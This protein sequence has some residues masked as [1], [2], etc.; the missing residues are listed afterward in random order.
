[1]AK[2]RV[3]GGCVLISGQR[4]TH[5][6][7]AGM[8]GERVEMGLHPSGPFAVI[9][10]EEAP[11]TL[12]EEGEEVAAPVVEMRP[13]N[14]GPVLMPGT[15]E[16]GPSAGDLPSAPAEVAASDTSATDGQA[17]ATDGPDPSVVIG[18]F[19]M[20]EDR[21][22]PRL[23]E[24]GRLLN[25]GEL[26]EDRGHVLKQRDRREVEVTLSED[27]LHQIRK[28]QVDAYSRH[29]R[30]EEEERERHKAAREVL[31][32]LK[33]DVDRLDEIT[34]RGKKD[35]VIDTEVWAVFDAGLRIF[36]RADTMEVL[37]A[38]PLGAEDRQQHLPLK[39]R[40]PAPATEAS[41]YTWE[42]GQER[43][44]EGGNV[45]SLTNTAPRARAALVEWVAGQDEG[46]HRQ[47]AEAG[48]RG[49]IIAVQ[50]LARGAEKD[51]ASAFG[52]MLAEMA[53]KGQGNEDVNADAEEP[54]EEPG[55]GTEQADFE[56][57]RA[58]VLGTEDEYDADDDGE[59]DDTDDGEVG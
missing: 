49:Q 55:D 42:P 34:S 3:E 41:T 8:E 29:K 36:V 4:Y 5:P 57:D 18:P 19:P 48:S 56:Q 38:F 27:E 40:T 37:Q 10:G 1:M 26:S 39:P 16:K 44:A 54:E 32:G 45:V 35:M 13:L 52:A 17:A 59:H 46:I 28:E 33:A 6:G 2:K 7:L 20:P 51:P 53:A 21:T 14:L 23:F 47:W 11:L 43:A 25:P 15:A 30:A 12:V 24:V 58:D 22:S 50:L 9:G 31:K